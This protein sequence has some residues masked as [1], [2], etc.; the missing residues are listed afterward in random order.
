MTRARPKCS[1]LLALHCFLLL[2]SAPRS[3]SNPVTSPLQQWAESS[4]PCPPSC[5]LHC[6][7]PFF[8]QA[9]NRAKRNSVMSAAV[10]KAS[11]S[12][13]EWPRPSR[14]AAHAGGLTAAWTAVVQPNSASQLADP[15]WFLFKSE[16]RGSPETP[17]LHTT[18]SALLSCVTRLC[19]QWPFRCPYNPQSLQATHLLQ[20]KVLSF[21]NNRNSW[22][23]QVSYNLPFTPTIKQLPLEVFQCKQT[24]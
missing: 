22:N 14:T 1:P 21:L 2:L 9:G 23:S 5:P 10:K 18:G 11:R 20:A 13:E 17:A 12:G 3:H 4:Q 19:R 15:V 7:P 24:L 6:S 8:H 16:Q